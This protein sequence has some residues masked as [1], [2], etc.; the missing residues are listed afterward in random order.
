M[1]KI[2]T[3]PTVTTMELTTGDGCIYRADVY[4]NFFDLLFTL[5]V[6]L[7]IFIF[8]LACTI[9]LNIDRDKTEVTAFKSTLLDTA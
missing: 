4:V 1:C 7:F 5:L 2:I 9:Q 6:F 3:I 8:I